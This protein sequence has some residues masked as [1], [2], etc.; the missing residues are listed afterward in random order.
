MCK[1][2]TVL[3][4]G[5]GSPTEGLDL[6]PRNCTLKR[7]SDGQSCGLGTGG[8]AALRGGPFSTPV[9]PEAQG[10]DWGWSVGEQTGVRVTT[11]G[12][13]PLFVLPFH[14]H[15]LWGRTRQKPWT[16]RCRTPLS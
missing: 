13:A 7:G 1:M 5:A 10:W 9:R 16:A 12:Q 4:V 2:K 8:E 3:G 11:R 6:M 14:G 15:A